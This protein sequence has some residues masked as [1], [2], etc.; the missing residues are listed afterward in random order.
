MFARFARFG[1]LATLLTLTSAFDAGIVSAESVEFYSGFFG[2]N[3][4]YGCTQKSGTFRILTS[5]FANNKSVYVH[6][7]ERDGTWSDLPASFVEALPDG[8]EVWTTSV[9]YG[10]GACPTTRT[11]PATFRFAVKV[12]PASGPTLWDNNGGTDFSAPA[13]SGDYLPRVKVLSFSA[14]AYNGQLSVAAAVKN[15]AYAKQ[16]DIAYSTNGWQSVL[17]A[18]LAFTSSYTLGYGAYVSPNATGVE[19]WQAQTQAVAGA[20]CFDYAIRY[21][22]NGQTYWDNNFGRNYHVCAA[23]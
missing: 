8:R 6:L 21:T 22:V 9:T 14:F 13:A 19:R 4:R 15:L 23:N 20:T 2:T 5:A 18:P 17:Y 12:V 11:A 16:V 10:Q 1:L 7:L 3:S